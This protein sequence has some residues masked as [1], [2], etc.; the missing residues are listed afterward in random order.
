ML[1]SVLS[2]QKARCEPFFGSP[3][4]SLAASPALSP[5]LL[6]ALSALLAHLIHQGS[7]LRLASVA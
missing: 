3:S 1:F 2:A 7:F 5:E 4:L 6:P